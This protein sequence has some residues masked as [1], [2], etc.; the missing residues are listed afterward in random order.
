MN[1]HS[2]LE[3]VLPTFVAVALNTHDSDSITAGSNTYYDMSAWKHASWV[4]ELETTT[5]DTISKIRVLQA[6]DASG[7]S[8]K[9]VTGFTFTPTTLNVAGETA[10]LE[11]DAEHL[12]W[13]NGFT[14][15][16]LQVVTSGGSVGTVNIFQILSQPRYSYKSRSGYTVRLPQDLAAAS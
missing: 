9:A 4:V 3:G 6:T 7:T 14:H 5:G 1:T 11:F 15:V 2:L 13:A 8:A 10:C 16:A 12:D